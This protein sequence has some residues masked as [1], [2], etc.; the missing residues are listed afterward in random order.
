MN[1]LELLFIF[2][3]MNLNPSGSHLLLPE[4]IYY[5]EPLSIYA[6]RKFEIGIYIKH[7]IALYPDKIE[8]RLTTISSEQKL[9]EHLLNI[10]KYYLIEFTNNN[11]GYMIFYNNLFEVKQ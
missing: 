1:I 6:E 7:Y 2:K 4:L 8:I 11:E 10:F 3:C 9:L 5:Y